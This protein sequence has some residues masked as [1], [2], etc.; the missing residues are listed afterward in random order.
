MSHIP[1]RRDRDATFEAIRSS[2]EWRSYVQL[3]D[4][5][6]RQ[7]ISEATGIAADELNSLEQE[8]GRP[9]PDLMWEWYRLFGA[10]ESLADETCTDYVMPIE[11]V[12][13][14]SGS[15]RIYG[16]NQDI[17]YCCIL[18]ADLGQPDPPVYFDSQG[19]PAEEWD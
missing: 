15:L 10:H 12:W 17:W 19:I 4:G 2:P 18:D 7:P 13:G 6:Y 14:E 3:I 1:G 16:E 9:L 8:G 5:W 11:R